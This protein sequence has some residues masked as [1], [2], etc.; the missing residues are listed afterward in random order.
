MPDMPRG[1]NTEAA[2][3]WRKITSQFDISDAGGLAILQ[4]AC[5]ALTSLRK[6]EAIVKDEGLSH[7]DR[8]NQQKAH[9]LLAMIRDTRA[10]YLA[11]LKMLNLDLEPLSNRRR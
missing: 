7:K 11:A 1:L 8:F 2:I 3:L 10:Q 4:T 5:E 9:P 6:M